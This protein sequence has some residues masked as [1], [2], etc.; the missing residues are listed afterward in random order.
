MW[1]STKVN[2]Q[3]S[4][5]GLL[6]AWPSLLCP[7][8]PGHDLKAPWGWLETEIPG[9]A[10]ASGQGLSREEREGPRIGWAGKWEFLAALAT[11]QWVQGWAWSGD[12]GSWLTTAP[13]TGVRSHHPGVCGTDRGQQ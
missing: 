10:W 5:G 11:I 13:T 2:W 4:Q 12:G 9:R 6:C 8:A 3:D 1:G 7:K